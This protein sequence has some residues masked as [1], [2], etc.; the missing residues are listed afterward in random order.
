ANND[1]P[2]AGGLSLADPLGNLF[3]ARCDPHVVSS[4]REIELLGLFRTEHL[5]K[6]G[7]LRRRRP[8][9][10]F[11]HYDLA[12][13]AFISEIEQTLRACSAAQQLGVHDE[14]PS[15]V[16]EGVPG[17]VGRPRGRREQLSRWRV[18]SQEHSLPLQANGVEDFVVP[19]HVATRPVYLLSQIDT[20]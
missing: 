15:T 17:V 9:L 20:Q 7:S 18:M 5:K 10:W 1:T 2:A 13:P 19:K 4:E 14:D 11:G 12:F 8:E 16:C 6:T 3:V